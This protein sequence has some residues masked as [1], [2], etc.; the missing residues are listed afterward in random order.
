MSD[1]EDR[2]KKMRERASLRFFLSAAPTSNNFIVRLA[3]ASPPPLPCDPSLWCAAAGVANFVFA[4][5][6]CHQ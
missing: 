1:R 6:I 5:T 4:W 2:G 3:F